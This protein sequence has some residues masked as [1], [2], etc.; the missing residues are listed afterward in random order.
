MDGR[1][2]RR[3]VASSKYLLG[4]VRGLPARVGGEN[5]HLPGISLAVF[6]NLVEALLWLVVKHRDSA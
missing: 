2:S 1:R 3:G 5:R 4:E 6:P